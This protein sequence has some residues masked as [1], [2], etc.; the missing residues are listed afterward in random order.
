M[1]KAQA[2]HQITACDN[3]NDDDDWETDADYVNNMTEEEQRYGTKRDLDAIDMTKYREETLNADAELKRVQQEE[4]PKAS[5]GYGGK[6]GVQKD[7]MDKSAE[8]HEYIGKVDKHVSQKDYASG[9]GGKFGVQSDRQDSSAVGWDHIEKVDKHESQKDYNRGFGGKFGVQTDRQDKSASGWDHIEKVDKHESQKD[10]TQGFGGKFGVQS[11]RQDKSA[12]GWDHIEK[13]EKHESQKDY[14][15]GFGGKYGI[16]KD[17]QDKTAVGWDHIEKVEKHESQTDH[18]KGFGGKFGV[19]KDR[20]DKTAHVFSEP[21][22]GIGTNYEP[23]KP[24]KPASVKASS[25]RARF[26]NLAVNEEDERR[27]QAEEERKKR[28]EGDAAMIQKEKVKFHE[29]QQQEEERLRRQNEEEERLREQRRKEMLQQQKDL[30]ME[31]QLKQQ[32]NLELREATAN[33]TPAEDLGSQNKMEQKVAA[34]KQAEREAA[35]E[36]AARAEKERL[37]AEVRR[38][39][40][41]LMGDPQSPAAGTENRPE[42]PTQEE[43]MGVT[44]YALFDYQ[45]ADTDEISFDP[46]DIL[47]NIEMIDE[48]WWRGWCNGQYGLFPANYVHLHSPTQ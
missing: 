45:A 17:R 38:Q 19:Q 29:Q 40:Q 36:A 20:M 4:G 26:E 22:G 44:A 34:K 23:T 27:K 25:L 6:F 42:P 11:D 7:R 48:G 2:G 41:L 39:E 31:N 8:S 28:Y 1:W 30:E 14:V 32:V 37:E 43:C 33:P 18:S 10:Y 21:Q 16:Q 24:E 9:F 15:V 46:D 3:G 13:V 47:T 12:A 5:Y 35:E